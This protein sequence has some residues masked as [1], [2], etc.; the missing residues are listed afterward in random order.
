[1]QILLDVLKR[2]DDLDYSVEVSSITRDEDILVLRVDT[3]KY[4]KDIEERRFKR[5]YIGKENEC[6]EILLDR[7]LDSLED[8]NE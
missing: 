3:Y 4:Y 8:K 7:I 6:L 1:M 2:I 5:T